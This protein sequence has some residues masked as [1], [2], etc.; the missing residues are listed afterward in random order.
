MIPTVYL[1]GNALLGKKY[2]GFF[3]GA[4][5]IIMESAIQLAVNGTLMRGLELNPNLL[6][7]GATFLYETSTN[8][9]YRLYS[10]GDVHPGMIRVDPASDLGVGAAISVEVWSVPAS[11]IAVVL[12]REPPGLC[13]GK[14]GLA[15]GE[16][17]LGVLAEPMLCQGQREITEYGGWRAYRREAHGDR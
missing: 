9:F 1:G 16:T 13:I 10:I 12:M 7:V 11:G 15:N 14:I 5:Q 8:P 17:V 2:L 4:E 6:E 3:C